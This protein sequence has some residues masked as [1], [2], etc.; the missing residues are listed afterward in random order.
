MKSKRKEL[1]KTGCTFVLASKND[2][3]EYNLKKF[4]DE[5]SIKNELSKDIYKK[6]EWKLI[7]WRND[8][9]GYYI[10]DSDYYK[11]MRTRHNVILVATIVVIIISITVILLKGIL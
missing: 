2:A 10:V 7:F 9:E 1:Y 4:Q 3:G 6:T 8:T 11:K 5:E